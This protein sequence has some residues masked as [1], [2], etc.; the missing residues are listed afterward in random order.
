VIAAYHRL[1]LSRRG[2]TAD[3][4]GATHQCL[5]VDGARGKYE[6]FS[7]RGDMPARVTKAEKLLPKTDV[8]PLITHPPRASSFG[9]G[10]GRVPWYSAG[11]SEQV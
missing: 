2:C 7:T 8:E 9:V 6:A 5:H 4:L 11:N 1:W 3:H 10:S